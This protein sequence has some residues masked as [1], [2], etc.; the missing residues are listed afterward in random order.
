MVSNFRNYFIGTVA[1][2]ALSV[3][4][5]IST[6]SAQGAGPQQPPPPGQG[7][8]RPG[9]GGFG[10]GMPPG[11]GGGMMMGG[12]ATMIDDNTHIYILRGPQLVKVQKSNLQVVGQTM[13]PG[14]DMPRGGEGF[15]RPGGG[16]RPGGPARGGGGGG[17][18]PELSET[19]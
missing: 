13:L 7:P 8:G 6:V 14:P 15:G 5:L 16:D 9:G 12:A 19:P 10:Q 11:G 1:L 4:A 2:A 17:I 18:P 3:P